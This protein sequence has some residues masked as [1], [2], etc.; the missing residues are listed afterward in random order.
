[1]SGVERASPRAAPGVHQKSVDRA[2]EKG[3]SIKREL[4]TVAISERERDGRASLLSGGRVPREMVCEDVEQKSRLERA[5]LPALAQSIQEPGKS[6]AVGGGGRLKEGI[7]AQPQSL[8]GR[9]LVLTLAPRRPL[10]L[11]PSRILSIL[12]V[13]HPGK[14]AAACSI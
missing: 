11:V 6:G 4:D 9:G 7:V 1:M 12:L 14:A 5:P 3:C 13:A 8:A 10:A 2:T